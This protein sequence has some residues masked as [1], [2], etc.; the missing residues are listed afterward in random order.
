[1]RENDFCKYYDTVGCCTQKGKMEVMRGNEIVKI[2]VLKDILTTEL[3]GRV[4]TYD[5]K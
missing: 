4:G 2:I 3:F 1:M 5:S